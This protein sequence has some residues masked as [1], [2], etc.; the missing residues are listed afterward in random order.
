MI[1]RTSN[2]HINKGFDSRPKAGNGP[3][4]PE[5]PPNAPETA[6]LSRKT[7]RYPAGHAKV[8]SSWR[9]TPGQPA[10]NAVPNTRAQSQ[11]P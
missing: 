3:A 11:S 5:C 4:R 2:T 9:G 7:L 1:E 6:P 8:C 10:S